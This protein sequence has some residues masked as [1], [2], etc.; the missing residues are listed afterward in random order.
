MTKTQQ[1]NYE[2]SRKIKEIQK[3]RNITLTDIAKKNNTSASNI[4]QK[5]KKLEEGKGIST[6]SFFEIAESLGVDPGFLL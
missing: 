6:T 3:I 5:I 2:I 1:R 4:F